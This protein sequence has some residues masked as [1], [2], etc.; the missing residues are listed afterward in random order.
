MDEK[1]N[2]FEMDDSHFDSIEEI[3]RKYKTIEPKASRNK[4]SDCKREELL[5]YIKEKEA[6]PFIG[7]LKPTDLI[8]LPDI[9]TRIMEYFGYQTIVLETPYGSKSRTVLVMSRWVN[10]FLITLQDA[11]QEYIKWKNWINSADKSKS[12]SE[13]QY[14]ILDAFPSL[15]QFM[16]IY[17]YHIENMLKKP[18][19]RNQQ[20]FSC[21]TGYIFRQLAALYL[22]KKYRNKAAI[23]WVSKTGLEWSNTWKNY[24]NFFQVGLSSNIA[25]CRANGFLVG[26]L[27]FA[28][29]GYVDD[30]ITDTTIN[31]LATKNNIEKDNVKCLIDILSGQNVEHLK[32]ILW[33]IG[34]VM[35]G[36]L[37]VRELCRQESHLTI[38]Q[39]HKPNL[40]EVCLDTIFDR[41]RTVLLKN[42]GIW[43]MDYNSNN[44]LSRIAQR[45]SN[46][47]FINTNE[48]FGMNYKDIITARIYHQINGVQVYITTEPDRPIRN[49]DFYKELFAG[50]T[51][52][53]E[54]AYKKQMALKEETKEGNQTS[55]YH[56]FYYDIRGDLNYTCNA[57]TIFITTEASSMASKLSDAK[58][59][60]INYMD[61]DWD[62]APLEDFIQKGAITPIVAGKLAMLSMVY[63]INKLCLGVDAFDMVAQS[64]ASSCH[65]EKTE[66]EYIGEF[67]TDCI[68][69][70]TDNLDSAEMVKNMMSELK[71]AETGY[72]D[73]TWDNTGD[74]VAKAVRE[75]LELNELDSVSM[76]DLLVSYQKWKEL[77]GITTRQPKWADF[78][79]NL[80]EH[81]K[82]MKNQ[83]L[84]KY[85]KIFICRK[86]MYSK[87]DKSGNENPA[88]TQC[89]GILGI[90]LNKA[91][92]EKLT[93]EKAIQ[94]TQEKENYERVL[95]LLENQ[96]DDAMKEIQ[97][98][99][100]PSQPYM[101]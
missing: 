28:M 50:K 1:K 42:T 57:Q 16:A 68:E 23:D 34:K 20:S 58:K 90:Q 33:L 11:D 65:E 41:L 74:K 98:F 76:Y 21:V 49:I 47:L 86:T 40:I 30:N 2:T 13:S 100:I 56:Q 93:N 59:T 35:L 88:K 22:Y 70:L 80:L 53:Y 101:P 25:N 87:Y 85:P 99:K 4:R 9:A 46:R 43:A 60:D 63:M 12:Q 55:K 91:W 54:G 6:N 36:D 81:L 31:N 32:K 39:C 44:S 62:L 3:I 26:G 5:N 73:I 10:G 92:L 29:P 52:T 18:N 64:T 24:L 61:I 67:Y 75:R 94:E 82:V 79:A 97:S 45:I 77:K 69:D 71:K 17:C 8:D 37:F 66:S 83:E 84:A 15:T 7:S 38:I 48:I 96:F 95:S 89:I 14:H 78:Y 72:E 51:V 27:R 19:G